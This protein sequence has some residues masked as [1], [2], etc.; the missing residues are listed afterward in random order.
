MQEIFLSEYSR[1]IL[2]YG[3]LLFVS[4]FLKIAAGL[5]PEHIKANSLSHIPFLLRNFHTFHI[6]S[7]FSLKW[8]I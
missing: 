4:V 1:N 8:Y 6:L 2:F 5:Y 7:Q 3:T